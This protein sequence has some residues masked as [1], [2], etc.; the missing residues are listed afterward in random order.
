MTP[1]RVIRLTILGAV[2][3]LLYGC[4]RP[5]LP[6]RQFEGEVA[7]TSSVKPVQSPLPEQPSIEMGPVDAQVRIIAFYPID[8]EHQQ[9]I[10]LLR[11][12]VE[13]HPGKVYARYTDYRTMRGQEAFQN[14]RMTTPGI[15]LNSE[16]EYT[17]QAEPRP[18][19]VDFTQDIGRYWTAEDL[20]LAVAQEVAAVYGR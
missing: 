17:I 1:R 19:T 12:V 11:Q 5:A 13:Q 14:A 4:G 8:D 15:M 6:G 10:D 18:Y 7:R 16:T 3:A 20:K 2:A 9:V